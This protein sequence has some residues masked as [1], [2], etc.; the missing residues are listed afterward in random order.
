[1]ANVKAVYQQINTVS[2]QRIAIIDIASDEDLSC[3]D[4]KVLLMLLSQLEGYSRPV[5]YKEENDP[6]NF[7]RINPE[8]IADA[9]RIKKKDVK[10]SIQWLLELGYIEMGSNETIK[11]GYRF[12]F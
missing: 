10:K 11:N 5:N 9:L 1:M 3:K 4:Y 6:L 12:T 8:S 7:K 2:V